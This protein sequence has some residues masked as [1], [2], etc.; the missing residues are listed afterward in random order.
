MQLN[1]QVKQGQKIQVPE[2][3]HRVLG[4]V[5]LAADL[6]TPLLD[7]PRHVVNLAGVHLIQADIDVAS[8]VGQGLLLDV[9][10]LV[11]GHCQLTEEQVLGAQHTRLMFDLV[12]D[13]DG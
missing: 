12:V 4:R 8:H 6:A 10:V 5:L 2:Q 7:A 13:V 9:A 3:W 11:V 1:L